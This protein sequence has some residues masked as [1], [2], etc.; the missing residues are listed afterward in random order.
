VQHLPAG[1]VRAVC[2]WERF[3]TFAREP[4]QRKVAID[5]R[6]SLDGIR[7]EVDPDLAGEDVVLWWRLFDQEL[8]VEYGDRRY[9][10]YLPV[11]GP[12]P[13]NR[14]RAFRKTAAQ[15]RSE[16]IEALAAQLGL[17]REA[18]ES[19]PDVAVLIQPGEIPAQTFVDPDPFRQLTYASPLEA[20]RAIAQY[21]G[22]AL[23]TLPADQLEAINVVVGT[24]LNKREVLA[25]VRACV[26][27]PS[28]ELPDA[29]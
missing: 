27:R 14:Y 16:R 22:R 8:F 3:C 12:I 29:E 28:E 21:L 9:G 18:L 17:P 23:A 5:A 1:G 15:T 25:Q 20:K 6:V 24:T 2:S 7:Y 4:E 10:P 19:R 26:V 13:L 11:D